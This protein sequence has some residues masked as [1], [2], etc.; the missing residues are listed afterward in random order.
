VKEYNI[1]EESIKEPGVIIRK[2]DQTLTIDNR[3]EKVIKRKEKDLRV[4]IA[5]ILFE[6]E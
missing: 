6:S 1:A 4:G 3:I 2:K 5:K